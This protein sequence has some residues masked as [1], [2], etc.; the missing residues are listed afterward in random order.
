MNLKF[1]GAA[2]E[3]TGSC[4]LLEA[5]NK[6][7]LI[8]CGFFQGG[9]FFAEKNREDF[10][11]DPS[12]IDYVFLTHAHQDHCG[13]LPKLRKEGFKGKILATEP[14]IELTNVMLA[15]SAEIM[16]EE[17][18]EEGREPLYS[19]K[20][21]MKLLPL[22]QKVKY[23]QKIKLTPTFW[24]QFRN[25]GHILGAAVIEI[26]AEGKKLVF[27]GDIGHESM[28]LIKKLADIREADYIICESTYGDK[29]HQKLKNKKNIFEQA[30]D[31]IIEKKG[32]LLIPAFALERTQEILFEINDLVEKQKI[33]KIDIFVDSPLAIRITRIFQRYQEFF[34]LDTKKIILSGDDIFEFKGL[35]YTPEVS[36]SKYINT[37]P[38]PKIIIAGSGMLN[39]GR[40]MYHLE[41]YLSDPTTH[42]LF[43]GYQVR[44]TRG[45]EILDGASNTEIKGNKIP[46][47]A[48]IS[49]TEAFSGHADQKGL[50]NWLS[51]FKTKKVKGIFLTHGDNE[52]RKALAKIIQEKFSLEAKLPKFGESFRL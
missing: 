27:S 52:A 29:I 51:H 36:Q 13:R 12:K 43:V 11:F 3:V 7:I 31:E 28:L 30:I 21:L 32:V 38:K 35:Q 6:K 20:D 49:Q 8:D 9:K 44:G 41:R 46:I 24:V 37:S 23:H 40:I 1:C 4:Y 15:D 25:A 2:G 34:N 48:K 26:W 39:G 45:R 47:R 17:Y 33:G 22:F 16:E 14:T 50:I 19:E 42:L 5:E 10:P 18:Q